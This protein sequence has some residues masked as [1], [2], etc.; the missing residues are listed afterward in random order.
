MKSLKSWSDPNN[1][2]QHSSSGPS[3]MW[4]ISLK[5]LKCDLQIEH[6]NI[7]WI[8][9]QT[10]RRTNLFLTSW[11]DH[12]NKRPLLT[13]VLLGVANILALTPQLIE[14]IIVLHTMCLVVTLFWKCCFSSSQWS[15]CFLLCCG[16]QTVRKETFDKMTVR[17]IPRWDHYCLCDIRSSWSGMQMRRQGDIQLSAFAK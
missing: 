17:G 14:G 4:K 8:D 6:M 2:E 7:T 10:D 1:F 13:Q 9:G 15:A 16:P 5:C 11:I 3:L 12:Y